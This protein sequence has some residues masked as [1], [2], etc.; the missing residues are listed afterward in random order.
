MKWLHYH[1]YYD[2][3]YIQIYADFD[4]TSDKPKRFEALVD[5]GRGNYGYCYLDTRNNGVVYQTSQN[6]VTYKNLSCK[7]IKFLIGVIYNKH[8]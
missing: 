2:P 6:A 1:N 3:V 7:I 8:I 5:T 4:A